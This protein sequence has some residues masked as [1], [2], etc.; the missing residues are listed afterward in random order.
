MRKLPV[1][2]W[3]VNVDSRL[4]RPPTPACDSTHQPN[5]VLES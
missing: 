3:V 5:I 4:A 2:M 1:F